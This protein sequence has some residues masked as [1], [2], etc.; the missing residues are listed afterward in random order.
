MNEWSTK[1][2]TQEVVQKMEQARIPCGPDLSPQQALDDPHF[3]A[4]GMYRT[5]DYPGVDNLPVANF[6]LAMSASPGEIRRRPPTCGE[7]TDEVLGAL[8]YSAEALGAL[9]DKR[10]I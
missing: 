7:H 3:Q 2:T 6:P 10:V 5:L 4:A 8:G 9:R 1:Y